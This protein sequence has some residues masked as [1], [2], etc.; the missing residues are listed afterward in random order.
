SLL[1]S[2][3]L[4]WAL[5]KKI[6]TFETFA[7]FR[8][9]IKIV[10]ASIAMGIAGWSLYSSLSTH[11]SQHLSGKVESL[12][13]SIAGAL[14]VLIFASYLLKIEQVHEISRLIRSRFSR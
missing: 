3:L 4:I 9:L 14:V 10:I 8:S 2:G 1:N 13:L 5:R 11:F 12:G 6:G 7:I